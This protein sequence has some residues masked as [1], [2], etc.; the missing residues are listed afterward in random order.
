MMEQW[1]VDKSQ[2]V[3]YPQDLIDDPDKFGGMGVHMKLSIERGIVTVPIKNGGFCVSIPVSQIDAERIVKDGS[4]DIYSDG[5]WSSIISVECMF[6]N[7][8][9]KISLL[10][11]LF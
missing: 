5:Y 6:K 9:E 8:Q 4:I 10:R 7:T 11:G 1:D 2:Q 3:I